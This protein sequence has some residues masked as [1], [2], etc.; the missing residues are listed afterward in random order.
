[1][2]SVLHIRI[3]Q[4]ELTTARILSDPDRSWSDRILAEQFED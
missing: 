1:V 4:S 2:K 3:A